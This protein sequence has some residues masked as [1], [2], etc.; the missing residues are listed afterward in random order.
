MRATHTDYLHPRHSRV[1]TGQTYAAWNIVQGH[2]KADAL[3]LSPNSALYARLNRKGLP[4]YSS[5][6]R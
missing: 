3:C 4:K 6:S 1:E 2:F 5:T